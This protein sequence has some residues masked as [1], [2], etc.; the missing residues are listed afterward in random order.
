MIIITKEQVEEILLTWSKNWLFP[1]TN[2]HSST[3]HS[4][5]D[6]ETSSMSIGRGM[7][8]EDAVYIYTMEY[9]SAIK[10]NKIM[11]LQ[12]HGCN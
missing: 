11:S 6:M 8:K 7:G 10:R 5:Q 12:Q 1:A 4:M 2:V 3:I 9:D